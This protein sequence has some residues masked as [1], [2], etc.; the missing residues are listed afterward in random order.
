MLILCILAGYVI[1]GIAVTL[2]FIFLCSATPKSAVKQALL[3]PVRSRSL[4][5][6]VLWPLFVLGAVVFRDVDE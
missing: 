4:Y 2:D 3:H 6:T 5:V 1:A